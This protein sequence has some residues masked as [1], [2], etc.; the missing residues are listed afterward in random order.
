MKFQ[1]LFLCV[2]VFNEQARACTSYHRRPSLIPYPSPTSDV[3]FNPNDCVW[4]SECDADDAL[5]REVNSMKYCCNYQETPCY[6][7]GC[8]CS[9]FSGCSPNSC[10][11]GYAAVSNQAIDNE[12]L[13]CLSIRSRRSL[14]FQSSVNWTL[15]TDLFL[16]S[17]L[18]NSTL[19][20]RLEIADQM[21]IVEVA[22]G[23]TVRAVALLTRD[24]IDTGLRVTS[25]AINTLRPHLPSSTIY[26]LGHLIAK[27]LGGIGD[28]YNFVIQLRKVNRGAFRVFEGKVAAA[29]MFYGTI[30]YQVI[31]DYHDPLT[32]TDF[33]LYAGAFLED[34]TLLFHDM[35]ENY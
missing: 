20:N 26:D 11:D 14:R 34:G 27:R 9:W 25:S 17:K 7:S 1:L 31:V 3:E 8:S 22:T 16:Y 15:E 19:L 10:D 5:A 32:R 13:C 30:I 29:V 21:F 33:T 2:L 12:F 6:P 24:V 4:K 35:F 18:S 23:R 28:S